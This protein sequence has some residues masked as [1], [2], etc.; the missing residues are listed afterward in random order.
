MMITRSL[1][2]IKLDNNGSNDLD[3]H[4][5]CHTPGA[6]LVVE[7]VIHNMLIQMYLSDGGQ[8]GRATLGSSHSFIRYA[9]F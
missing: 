9:K 6:H 3:D 4:W 1:P 2:P 7:I 5:R 8:V